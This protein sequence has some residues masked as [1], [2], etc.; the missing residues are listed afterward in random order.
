MWRRSGTSTIGAEKSPGGLQVSNV[1]AAEARLYCGD[2]AYEAQR[3]RGRYL[4][5][6]FEDKDWNVR[7]GMR[8]GPE[9]L[10]PRAPLR[11]HPAA[12]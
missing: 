12:K 9:C 6:V 11:C 1:S 5:V 7:L 3:K 10:Q 4:D 8:G 2:P